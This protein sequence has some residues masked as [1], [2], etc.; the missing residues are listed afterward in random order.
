[1]M[2]SS[3]VRYPVGVAVDE[4]GFV[5]VCG[6]FVRQCCCFVTCGFIEQEH[7]IV[8]VHCMMILLHSQ[9]VYSCQ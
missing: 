8:D 6:L 7:L 2:S 9:F 1:M 5:Y 3:L 4:Y